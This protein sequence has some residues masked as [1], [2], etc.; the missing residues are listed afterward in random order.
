M[1]TGV[2]LLH[3]AALIITVTH[4][5]LVFAYTSLHIASLIHITTRIAAMVHII[6]AHLVETCLVRV[7]FRVTIARW[8]ILERIALQPEAHILLKLI[9]KIHCWLLIGSHCA[10]AL[11]IARD[12]L[13]FD[14]FRGGAMHLGSANSARP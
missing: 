8:K 10:H 4:F 9:D 6:D 11:I 5:A 1:N 3:R 12:R 2:A 7:T 14:P 13:S